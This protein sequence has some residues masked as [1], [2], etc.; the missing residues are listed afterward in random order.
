MVE[1]V[2]TL[3]TLKDAFTNQS[4]NVSVSAF[5]VNL[6]LSALLSFLL[7]RIYV[8]YGNALSNRKKLAENFL[9]LS[10]T[11]TLIITVVKSSLALS[12]GLVG[13]L[14]IVRFRTAIKE[15]EELSYLFLAIAI[16]LGFGADQR[17]ITLVA[18][19]MV[20]GLI[21]LQSISR[22]S[23]EHQNLYLQISSHNPQKARLKDIVEIL[24]LHSAG[25]S[26][27][28]FDE[29]KEMLEATFLLEFEDFSPL[30]A[31]KRDLLRLGDDI[32][33]TFLDNKGIGVIG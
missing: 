4:V 12:L 18:F 24:K 1:I 10:V 26:M 19:A 25:V 15:P 11:I 7:G 3:Q 9:L 21:W 6:L 2:E 28:R 13:A 33:I 30:E 16:G 22:R 23:E 14:S 27:K 8:R 31:S 20:T 29:T 17:V 5:F 32:R